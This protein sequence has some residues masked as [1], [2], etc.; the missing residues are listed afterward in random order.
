MADNKSAIDL[1]PC[2]LIV[3]QLI[4]QSIIQS[5]IIDQINQNARPAMLAGQPTPRTSCPVTTPDFNIFDGYH[6]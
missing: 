4:N 1:A 5:I 6:C 3:N 2:T